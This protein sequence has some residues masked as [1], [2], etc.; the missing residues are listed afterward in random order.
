MLFSDI[1]MK[2]IN[3]YNKI[4][5]IPV[6]LEKNIYSYLNKVDINTFIKSLY[7]YLQKNDNISLPLKTDK[8]SNIQSV[9]HFESFSTENGSNLNSYS[10]KFNRNRNKN[11]KRIKKL[12]KIDRTNIIDEIDT[13]NNDN[14][15]L[16]IH[17][18]KLIH[19]HSQYFLEG[20]DE[21]GPIYCDEYYCY[22]VYKRDNNFIFIIEIL[23]IYNRN[24][25]YILDSF[26]FCNL[27]HELRNQI[28]D[29]NNKL[30][31]QYIYYLKKIYEKAEDYTLKKS[32]ELTIDCY[33]IKKYKIL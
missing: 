21:Y 15:N 31:I 25:R 22:N 23:C 17:K 4:N 7:G 6:E 2:R 24:I 1:V 30:R 33:N 20:Y 28:K 19:T 13:E 27:K 12:F 32:I 3:L 16:K 10:K 9:K 11:K 8:Q 26:E 5:S 29:I 14:I 18:D